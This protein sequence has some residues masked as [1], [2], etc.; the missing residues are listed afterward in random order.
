MKNLKLGICWCKPGIMAQC[1][2][3]DAEHQQLCDFWDES[4][5]SL[6]CLNNDSIVENHC[7]S[8]EAQAFG[9]E[10][11]VVTPDDIDIPDEV[12]EELD[13]EDLIIPSPRSCRDCVL[14]AC[15]WLIKEN[16]KVQANGNPGL[17]GDDLITI[18]SQCPDYCDETMINQSVK[19]I[20]RGIKP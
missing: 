10:H 3:P 1:T 18:A 17:N 20:Q 11:G 13:I 14:Y 8:P 12:E 15:S 4:S 5:D 16:Q 9:R 6:K 2:A 7:Y 19:N